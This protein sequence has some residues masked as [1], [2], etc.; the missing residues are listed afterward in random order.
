MLIA[1]FVEK[2][3]LLCG[4]VSSAAFYSLS[5]HGSSAKQHWSIPTSSTVAQRI[6]PGRLL[7]PFFTLQPP[8]ATQRKHADTRFFFQTSLNHSP[9][10]N[11]SQSPL[12]GGS[13]QAYNF[14]TIQP[15]LLT[16]LSYLLHHSCE[17]C[18]EQFSQTGFSFTATCHPHSGKAWAQQVGLGRRNAVGTI[19]GCT[20]LSSPL[21]IQPPGLLLCT[22][23]EQCHRLNILISGNS[24]SAIHC[25]NLPQK[26]S[27]SNRWQVL[28]IPKTQM[29]QSGK[30]PH[31]RRNPSG[32][33]IAQPGTKGLLFSAPDFREGDSWFHTS[34]PEAGQ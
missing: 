20:A 21:S 24:V 15:S 5:E 27:A 32:E 16:F 19:L 22:W 34:S 29:H 31:S 10:P 28:F 9:Q 1:H 8:E 26:E 25:F 4:A 3:L 6:S 13:Y 7:S 12:W 33:F 14:I 23:G 2:G 30:Y 18:R 11:W 17:Q